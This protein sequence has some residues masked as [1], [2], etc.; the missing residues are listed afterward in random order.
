[1]CV[2]A[3]VRMQ[4]HIHTEREI[5]GEH[6]YTIGTKSKHIFT[7][8]FFFMTKGISNTNQTDVDTYKY[9]TLLHL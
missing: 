6:P 3:C 9:L 8:L 5:K 1:M 4:A 7:G 2:C